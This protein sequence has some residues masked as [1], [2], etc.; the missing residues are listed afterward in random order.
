MPGTACNNSP[1]LCNRRYH[2]IT[3]L[4]AHNSPF[5]RN[6]G[7]GF[8]LVGSQYFNAVQ[9]L[10]AGV[11]LLHAE[12]H[13]ADGNLTLC[14]TDCNVMRA[15]ILSD[16]LLSMKGWLDANQAEVVTLI[17]VNKDAAN[18]LLFRQALVQADLIGLSYTPPFPAASHSAVWP[19][20]AEMI[21]NNTRLVIFVDNYNHALD[22]CVSENTPC[23]YILDEWNYV[24]E[25][26]P[27]TISPN[28]IC[29]LHR[30]ATWPY[31]STVGALN[32]AMLPLLNHIRHTPVAEVASLPDEVG[33]D[34]INSPS[35]G[36]QQPGTL[37][38]HAKRCEEEWE[39][40]PVFVMVDFWNRGPALE[41][42]DRMNGVRGSVTGRT[43]PP[44][45]D[46]R[47][48]VDT[49]SGASTTFTFTSADA[50]R[51]RCFALLV[52][53]ETLF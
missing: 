23:P 37:G 22:G 46:V 32:R 5:L 2:E 7:T 4:G 36:N 21:Y 43:D 24:F 14:N 50:A 48:D 10:S 28:F 6:L 20:L 8:S 19:T 49:R 27:E 52:L 17:L 25:T 9:S 47:P 45:E 12:V 3:Y 29:D 26:P 39:R 18:I 31:T 15:G 41:V 30:P 16:W 11:R 44:P 35:E 51:A 13:L 42:V 33:I 38:H 53:V 1:L 34:D 40:K